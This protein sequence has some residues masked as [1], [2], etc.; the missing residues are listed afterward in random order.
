MSCQIC[1]S[2]G[3]EG[4]KTIFLALTL[5]LA[6]Y[7]VIEGDTGG[8]ITE[9]AHSRLIKF[10]ATDFRGHFCGPGCDRK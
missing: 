9:E 3:S 10:C 2:D 5:G 6:V 8:Q 7:L 1:L 4:W